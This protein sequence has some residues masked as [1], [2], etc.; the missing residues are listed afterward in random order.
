VVKSTKNAKSLSHHKTKNT[1]Q[2]ILY[3]GEHFETLKIAK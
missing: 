3:F 2:S 1:L